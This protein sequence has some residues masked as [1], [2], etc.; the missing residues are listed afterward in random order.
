MEEQLKK[1]CLYDS[2]VALGAKMSPF[3][4]FMM[5]IQYSTITD[6][7]LAV[8]NH[9]GMFDVSHM[10]EIF[11]EGPDAEKFVNHIF[12]NEIKGYEAGKVLYGMML[13]PDGGVV[14]DLLVYREFKPDHFLLVVNAATIDKDYAWIMDHVEGFNVKV[15]NQSAKWGQVAVQGPESEKTVVE[16]LGIKNAPELTKLIMER[17]NPEEVSLY[18]LELEKLKSF[19]QDKIDLYPEIAKRITNDLNIVSREIDSVNSITPSEKQIAKESN[20]DV[21]LNVNDRDM[22]EDA[23]R[24]REEQEEQSE[25]QEK[26][27]KLR[28]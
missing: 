13:Y 20:T 17:K 19:L 16:V 9:V 3:A 28:R 24:N 7:H 12:T 11:V 2:H 22:Y 21:H 18:K 25:E 10:G 4:G 27:R 8:R 6:E 15:D 14:D 23:N 5:P 1:T 26:S